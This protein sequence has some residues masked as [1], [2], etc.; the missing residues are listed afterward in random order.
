[1]AAKTTSKT[2]SKTTRQRGPNVALPETV[3]SEGNVSWPGSN[4][5]S[6]GKNSA[7]RQQIAADV[8]TMQ[9][10]SV[11]RYA[12]TGDAEQKA[13]ASLFRKVVDEVHGPVFGVQTAQ[14]NDALF[15]KLGNRRASNK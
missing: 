13:F 2:A 6:G 3:E 9:M 1:M 15:V 5:G 12:I 11:R 7:L 8:A 14:Q 4:R 10:G